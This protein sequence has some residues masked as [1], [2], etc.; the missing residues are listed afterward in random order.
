M[1]MKIRTLTTL[2]NISMVTLAHA[3]EPVNC[4]YMMYYELCEVSSS[5]YCH[6]IMFSLQVY[7]LR[8]LVTT[9]FKCA[10]TEGQL[11]NQA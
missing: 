6:L 5:Q 1:M 2:R 4:L 8:K 11:P 9:R 7:L 3:Y 10:F